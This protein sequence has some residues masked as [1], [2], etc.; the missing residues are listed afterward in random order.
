MSRT[1]R[2]ARKK[3]ARKLIAQDGLQ[4]Y[5]DAGHRIDK[6]KVTQESL[7]RG[8]ALA[9]AGAVF[10]SSCQKELDRRAILLGDRGCWSFF[11]DSLSE[12]Q[13]LGVVD[14]LHAET[15]RAARRFAG[16]SAKTLVTPRY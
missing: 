3:L 12:A 10:L 1:G 6:A 9:Q 5:S 4:C 11:R 13:K 15:A 14:E 7:V 16:R 2:N 8:N